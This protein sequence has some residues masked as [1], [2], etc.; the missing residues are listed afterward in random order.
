MSLEEIW[1]QKSDHRLEVAAKELSN[2]TEEAEQVIRAEICRR[3]MPEPPITRRREA[4]FRLTSKEDQLGFFGSLVGA[5]ILLVTL[6]GQI[7]G[8]VVGSL[9]IWSGISSA[10]RGQASFTYI[11]GYHNPL[12]LF[13]FNPGL[14]NFCLGWGILCSV[15]IAWRKEKGSKVYFLYAA[16]FGIAN[17]IVGLINLFTTLPTDIGIHLSGLLASIFS[18]FMGYSIVATIL[19]SWKIKN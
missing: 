15:I 10:F 12:P 8:I 4:T 3:G 7:S 13:K 6:A 2:Y 1:R 5:A 18:F 11:S 19:Q 16:I 9:M 14:G 17:L